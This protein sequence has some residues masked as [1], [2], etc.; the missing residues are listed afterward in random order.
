MASLLPNAHSVASLGLLLSLYALYVEHK[1]TLLKD[2]P[3]EE[4]VALCDIRSLGAS[5]R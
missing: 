5:C 1:T 3:T 4:F 2:D